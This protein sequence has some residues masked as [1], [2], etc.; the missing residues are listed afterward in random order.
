MYSRPRLAT[1]LFIFFLGRAAP[2]RYRQIQLN[3]I[4]LEP[5][6]LRPRAVRFTDVFELKDQLMCVRN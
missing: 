6:R 1:F 3:R 5:G 4:V 2:A